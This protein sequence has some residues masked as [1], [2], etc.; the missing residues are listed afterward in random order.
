RPPPPGGVRFLGHSPRPSPDMSAGGGL[1]GGADPPN[2]PTTPPY[3]QLNVGLTH[4]FVLL[5]LGTFQ[6]RFDVF[7]VLGNNYVLRDG[8]GVGVFAKQFGPPRGF[9]GGLKKVF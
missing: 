3:Q 7:N 6:A 9:F 8:T 2:A 1:R 5:A 4:D